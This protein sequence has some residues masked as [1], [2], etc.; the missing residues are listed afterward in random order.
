MVLD[1]GFQRSLCRW[2]AC[3]TFFP[4]V[5]ALHRGELGF[6]R[7]DLAN[8]GCRSASHARGSFSNRDSGLIGEAL[9]DPRVE[10]CS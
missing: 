4:K 1:V 3:A 6:V 9:D 2:K 7:Y 8:K 10:H 5:L